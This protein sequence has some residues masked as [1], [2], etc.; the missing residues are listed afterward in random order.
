MPNPDSEGV[1]DGTD[2]DGGFRGLLSLAGLLGICCVGLA[3]LLGGAAVAGG[4][5]AGVTM[6][7]G[8]VD[9]FAGLLVTGLATALPLV[10]IGLI[11]HRRAR[12]Q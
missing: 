3:A 6:A 9:T 5:V 12:T 10:V 11:L 2:Q 1:L 4:S 7:S 8:V